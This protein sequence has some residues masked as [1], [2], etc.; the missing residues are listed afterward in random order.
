[1][2]T[3]AQSQALDSSKRPVKIANDS[4]SKIILSLEC[5]PQDYELNHGDIVEVY[6]EDDSGN[7]PLSISL[8]KDILQIYPNK[9]F[10]N[11]FVFKN[12]INITK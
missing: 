5:M 3:L 9:S 11:W 2:N 6:I 4:E 12:G 10:G 8:G 1:M 7:L